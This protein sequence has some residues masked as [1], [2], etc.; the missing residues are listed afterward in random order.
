M[1]GLLRWSGGAATATDAHGAVYH[2]GQCG[3]ELPTTLECPPEERSPNGGLTSLAAATRIADGKCTTIGQWVDHAGLPMPCYLRD[4]SEPTSGLLCRL[5]GGDEGGGASLLVEYNCATQSVSP[6]VEQYGSLSYKATMTGPEACALPTSYML[7]ICVG[8]S[9][10]AFILL[11]CVIRL[12]HRRRCCRSRASDADASA[13]GKRRAGRSPAGS[14]GEQGTRAGGGGS[15][16]NAP[17]SSED[18]RAQLLASSDEDDEAV[19]STPPTGTTSAYAGPDPSSN[20]Y[21]SSRA[22]DEEV[23]RVD[24]EEGAASA[25]AVDGLEAVLSAAGLEDRVPT[26]GLWCRAQ[27]WVSVAHLRTGGPKVIDSLVKE[28]RLKPTGARAKRLKKELK[29]DEWGWDVH[30]AAARSARG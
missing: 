2:W 25:A 6:T 5:Y 1:K 13:T 19:K 4:A 28:L 15:S 12:L 11:V 7:L 16:S 22:N 17:L 21:S 23:G 3:L 24:H 14:R 30:A 10:V 29:R 27:G 8:A 9:A 26:A 18:L 20:T